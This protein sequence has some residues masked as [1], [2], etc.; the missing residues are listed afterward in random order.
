MPCF[1]KVSLI[2]R[3]TSSTCITKSPYI[4]V[5]LFPKNSVVGKIGVCGAGNGKYKKNGFLLFAFLSMY[6]TALSVKSWSTLA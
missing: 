4:L 5:L 6:F 1:F 2:W 3:T